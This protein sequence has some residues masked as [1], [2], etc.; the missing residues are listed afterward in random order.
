MK[1]AIFIVIARICMVILFIHPENLF[2]E[3]LYKPKLY[4]IGRGDIASIITTG[5]LNGDGSPDIVLA[6]SSPNGSKSSIIVLLNKGDGTF[7]T[8]KTYA[9]P[10]PPI[11]LLVANLNRNNTYYTS[12]IH[13]GYYHYSSGQVGSHSSQHM[14]TTSTC[15]Y[16]TYGGNY[17]PYTCYQ[18]PVI[19]ILAITNSGKASLLINKGNGDFFEPVNYPIN[20]NPLSATISDINSDMLSDLVIYCASGRIDVLLNKG[21]G[22]FLPNSSYTSNSNTAVR[23]SMDVVDF[24][25]DN[26]PDIVSIFGING[27]SLLGVRINTSP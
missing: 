5:D 4:N 19:D 3:L 11:V 12:D 23:S 22:A 18:Y 10:S 2:A 9:V 25:G 7:P 8:Q 17:Y 6:K 15:Y 21:N 1:S 16:Y 14:Y 20:T 27:W 13:Y 26:K 24:N